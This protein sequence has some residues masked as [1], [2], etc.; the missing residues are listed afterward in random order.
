MRLIGLAV[1]LALSLLAPLAAEAQQAGK[2]P[3]LGFL[4]SQSVAA[5]RAQDEAFRQGMR[6]LGYVE[7]QAFTVERRYAEGNPEVLTRLAAELERLKV[8]IIV[9]PSSSAALAV[10]K[11]TSTTP[12]VFAFA[13]DPVGLGLV[14]SLAR[15]GGNVTGLTP[16]SADLS[17]KRLEL[18][19]EAVPA[20]SRIALLSVSTYP[21]QARQVMVRDLEAAARM[22][23]LDLRVLEVSGRDGLDAAFAK[24]S[25][26]RLGAVTALPLPFLTGE[27]RRI[28]E[29][30]LRN[31]LPSVF[32]W[33]EYVEVGGL[34]SYGAGQDDLIRRAATYVDKILKGAKPAE[35][36][37]EQ[38]K[39][40]ELV[41]NLKTAKMLG[42]TIPQ[43]VLG[44][45][46]QVIE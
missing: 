44:R 14:A 7:G 36:P 38:P 4:F 29:L 45:A 5:S 30:A 3:R 17:A 46:D 28:A 37:V 8:D 19:K 35:L 41:I 12:I 34:M 33:R 16:M 31:R 32:H 13:N 25:K 42:L 43:S 1:V 10:K 11:A 26:D 39:K 18:F 22:L 40:F 23:Q 27:R 20:V 6:E 2:I 24:M 15:P 21:Q 9:A